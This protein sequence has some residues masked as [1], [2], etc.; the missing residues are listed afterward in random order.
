[1]SL[2]TLL[3]GATPGQAI[4]QRAT[5]LLDAV[6][7]RL[8][9]GLAVLFLILAAWRVLEG[10]IGHILAPLTMAVAL[11]ATAAVLAFLEARRKRR[12]KAT[13]PPI[14][15]LVATLLEIAFAPKMVR[16]FSIGSL[17]YDLLS[18]SSPLTGQQQSRRATRQ[19]Y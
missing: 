18:G 15:P 2:Y 1:M 12:M 16:W 14:G 3:G 6:L 13:T 17:L 7:W 11:A 8:L 9:L 4:E 5:R 10:L 19:R